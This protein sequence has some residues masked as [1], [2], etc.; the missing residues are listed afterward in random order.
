MFSAS[1]GEVVSA[2]TPGGDSAV[3]AI[4]DGVAFEPQPGLDAL[5][6]GYRDQVGGQLAGEL[7]NAY[8]GALEAAYPVTRDDAVIAQALGLPE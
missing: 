1:I 2:P 4:V 7:L 8:V 3:V 5:I 6:G